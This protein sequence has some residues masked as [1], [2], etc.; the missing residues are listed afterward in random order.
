MNE[1]TLIE[2]QAL[3]IPNTLNTLEFKLEKLGDFV[4]TLEEK[5]HSICR[6]FK[7]DPGTP[8]AAPVC[9]TKLGQ[10]I[11]GSVTK[12]DNITTQIKTILEVLEI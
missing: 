4:N 5:L 1:N 9:C 8:A 11:D 2:T 7:D 3:E 6:A 12:V 10:R